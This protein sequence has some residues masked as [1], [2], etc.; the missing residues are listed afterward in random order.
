MRKNLR[1]IELC[2]IIRWLLAKDRRADLFYFLGL[3]VLCIALAFI[4]VFD[5]VLLLG[6]GMILYAWILTLDDF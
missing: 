5:A 3:I 2:D 6:G 1:N 4:S